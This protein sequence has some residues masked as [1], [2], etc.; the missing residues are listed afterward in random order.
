LFEYGGAVVASVLFSGVSLSCVETVVD[1]GTCC[2][3]P[4]VVFGQVPSLGK[5]FV[6]SF[7]DDGALVASDLISGSRLS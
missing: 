2:L 4:G 3:A 7:E 6:S 5:A 1:E